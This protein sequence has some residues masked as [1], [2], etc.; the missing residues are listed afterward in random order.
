MDFHQH[1]FHTKIA[2]VLPQSS[3]W[4][5]NIVFWSKVNLFTW[6]LALNYMCQ[7]FISFQNNDYFDNFIF[8]FFPKRRSHHLMVKCAYCNSKAIY[9]KPQNYPYDTYF[10]HQVFIFI[11]KM[12]LPTLIHNFFHFFDNI[13]FI[14]WSCCKMC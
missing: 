3:K 9:N 5:R 13:L 14:E 11:R 12:K 2:S 4:I 7:R 10:N 8:D 6:K 1:E